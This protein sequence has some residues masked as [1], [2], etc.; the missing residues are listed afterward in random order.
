MKRIT[1][2]YILLFAAF[3][4]LSAENRQDTLQIPHAHS[5]LAETIVDNAMERAPRYASIV[6]DYRS[7]SYVK[8]RMYVRKKNLLVRFVPSMFRLKKGVKE[9]LVESYSDLHFTAPNI[10]DQKVKAVYG[11]VDRY[12]GVEG[13]V[14]DYFHV[15]IYAPFLLHS[16]LLSPL[17]ESAKKYYTY[18]VDSVIPGNDH[19]SYRITFTPRNKS[20]QLV[21]GYMVITDG[22]WSVRELQF[23]GRSEYMRFDNLIQ[24]GDVNTDSEY[25]P[26]RYDLNTTF[27]FL[28]NTIDGSYT[29]MLDYRSIE[30]QEEEEE[31]REQEDEGFFTW[32]QKDKYDLT[33]SYNLQSDTTRHYTDSLTF[34]KLR[35]LP[36]TENEHHVYENYYLHRDTIPVKSKKTQSRQFW[37]QVGDMLISDYTVNLDAI[38]SVKC[39]PLINPFLIN[40]SGRDGFSYR[41][42]FKYSRLFSHDRLLRVAARVGYNFK[43]SEFYWRLTGDY[44]YWPRK[45]ASLHL[46]IGNGNR[47]YTSEFLDEI[48]QTNDTIFDFDKLPLDYFRDFYIDFRHRVEVTNGFH[49]DVGFS[50]H[51]RTPG[52]K[53]D[54]STT[55]PLP[56]PSDE[57]EEILD[58]LQRDY[59]SFAPRIVLSWTPGQYYYMNGERKI[60]LH[61]KFPTF[62][63]DWE[64]GVKGILKTTGVYERMEFD[65][66]HYVSLGLMKTLYYR[67]GMGAFTDQDEMYFVDFVNFSRNNLPVGWND[68]IGGVFQLLDRRWYNASRKYIRANVTYEAPFLALPRLLKRTRNVLNERL[69]LGVLVMPHLNP[70]IEL[71]YGIGTHIF[72]LGVFVANTNGKFSD[73]GFKIT[74]ELFN[75]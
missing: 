71:G 62:S 4:L 32:K 50:A 75:R 6:S 56:P 18:S 12:R 37:G 73:V 7:D 65:M 33:D 1:F 35:P 38:G 47:I 17:S 26:Q 42:D 51:R 31:E 36:L 25:L 55:D 13:D 68:E 2:T 9:Y 63:A 54:L 40:Y 11:T 70:Y 21:E 39:S 22:V 74:L 52:K 8:G 58:K 59:K 14:L 34:N 29:A 19:T 3:S 28:G 10:Y 43:H 53:L 24:M 5:E 15:N 44:D 61:S 16:K 27:H 66:Q 45:R 48:K 64:R 23:S 41:Q 20:Y 46:R 60:N 67:A 30:L 57:S 69:Y 49:F 72:D